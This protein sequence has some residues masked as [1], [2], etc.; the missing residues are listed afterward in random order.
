MTR[1][2]LDILF[3]F[4]LTFVLMTRLYQ[5]PI[6]ESDNKTLF[7]MI[8]R[9]VLCIM[10]QISKNTVISASNQNNYA[11]ILAEHLKQ[12]PTATMENSALMR[13]GSAI[14]KNVANMPLDM[15]IEYL[16]NVESVI[17][18]VWQAAYGNKN[19]GKKVYEISTLIRNQYAL[20]KTIPAW[21]DNV[22]G[23]NFDNYLT[24][25]KTVKIDG[26]NK[27]TNTESTIAPIGAGIVGNS[28]S[29]VDLSGTDNP[30]VKGTKYTVGTNVL[31][32]RSMGLYGQIFKLTVGDFA[33]F[34]KGS[35]FEI[36]GMSNYVFTVSKLKSD[37]NILYATYARKA[38]A[39]D[40]T[41]KPYGKPTESATATQAKVNSK[42]NTSKATANTATPTKAEVLA[43][44]M[45]LLDTIED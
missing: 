41:P 36:N 14:L 1:H 6:S 44:V 42:A 9:K 38:T 15:K 43:R 12:N 30:I 18:E 19:A 31:V 7:V 39:T 4:V 27:A 25:T 33:L 29:T 23:G 16:T 2:T 28:A 35:T 20:D 22:L 17:A 34:S 11:L 10:N 32:A 40:N 24:A 37:S 21:V 5:T 13:Q 3:T 8:Y 45:A 26:K